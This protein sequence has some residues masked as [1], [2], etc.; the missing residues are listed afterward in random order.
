MPGTG[1]IGDFSIFVDDD[2]GAYHVRTGFDIVK[3]NASFTG[4]EAHVSA[5]HT[6]KASEGPAMFKRNGTYYVTAGTGCCACIG[7]SSLYVLTA[8]SPVGPWTFQGDVG[9][10]PGRF[11][12]H[13]ATNYVTK[14]RLRPHGRPICRHMRPHVERARVSSDRRRAALSSSWVATD[15]A[16]KQCGSETSGTQG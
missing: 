7:G 8:P 16:A 2:G 14:A 11:D 1:R 6:P 15:R 13:S 9:S 5:F 3:L 10:N 12:P 4:P